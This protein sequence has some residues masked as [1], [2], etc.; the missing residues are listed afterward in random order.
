MPDI[1]NFDLVLVSVKRT[2]QLSLSLSPN[3][4]AG[5]KDQEEDGV[6]GEKSKRPKRTR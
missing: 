3:S 2:L 1:R 6:K 4:D 5:K